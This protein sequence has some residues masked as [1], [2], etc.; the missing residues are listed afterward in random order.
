MFVM[1][2]KKTLEWDDV[3]PFLYVRAAFDGLSESGVIKH[4][5][6]DEM[7]DYT[8]VQFAVLNLLFKCQKTI[9]G[10]F[11]QFIHPN[12]MNSLEDLRNLY[13]GAEFAELTKSYRSTYEIISFAQR[14]KAIGA[15]DA[16]ERHG[17]E[18]ALIECADPRDELRRINEMIKRFS[19]S[20]YVSLGIIVKTEQD[21]KRLFDLLDGEVNL[22]T[23]E[24]TRFKDGASVM[25]VKMSKGLEFDEVIIPGAGGGNYETEYEKG[26]LYIACT[27]AMHRL[28]LLIE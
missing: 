11:G 17:E 23:P 24:S 9:L 3:Y 15:I 8:P 10:D 27:R 12:H 14:I 20:G 28:T 22:I 18:P 13:D 26:L 1:P 16:I 21:A 4:L 25:S 7:Q 6:V 5:V 2:T 19:E